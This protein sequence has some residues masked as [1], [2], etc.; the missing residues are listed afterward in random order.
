[1]NFRRSFGFDGSL[2]FSMPAIGAA[3]IAMSS[4]LAGCGDDDDD[5]DTA[6]ARVRVA[7]LS[8][9][10]PAVD[11]CLAATGSG[12]FTG[13][14][15]AGAGGAAG[16]SYGKVTKYLDVD[17]QRYDV[18]LVAPGSTSC[19]T[20]LA[21]LPDYTQ[22][23]ALA[24]D[25]SFT[26]AA[27]GKLAAGGA[28][29]LRAYV[30]DAAVTAAS[31]KLRFIHASPATPNVDVGLGGGVAFTPVFSGVAFGGIQAGQQGYVA[32]GPLNAVEISARAT[33][34]TADVLA[35]KPASLPAGAI[36]TAF[37]IGEIGNAQTPLRVLLC[38]DN[39]EPVGLETSCAIVGAA[40][41]RARIR[42]AH[43]SP[44]APA[45]D[46]CVAP[47]GT[48]TFTGP[49][50]K[51]L[52]ATAGLSYPQITEYVSLPVASFKVRV[53][54]AT[55]T[56]CAT[57][58]VP[59]TDNVALA[60]DLIATVAAVGVL[61]PSGPAAGNPAFSLAVFGDSL[62]VPA[63]SIKLRFVHASPGTPAVDV[64]LLANQVFTR[65]FANVAF[66][67]IG[68]NTGLDPQ[69]YLQTTPIAAATISA[70][71]ANAA[72]DALVVPGVTLPANAIATAFAIGGKTGATTNP[73]R[74]LLCTD[75]VRTGTLLSQ[76]AVAP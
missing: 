66:G 31:A 29:T 26:I 45:V 52:G 4:M 69:G 13:P 72:T 74:V 70:R 19:A 73:L 71:V 21:G 30:D 15:L 44:D 56:T 76:C 39:A 54:L 12:V 55:A 14:V 27:T 53:V 50:L 75:S 24:A 40:P 63:G 68:T 42:I 47:S 10:A 6:I 8:P 57:K 41:E 2:I 65:L 22:L 48:E 64:G 7:H 11:F 59:D 51:S 60:K 61:D 49:L 38:V 62:T 36:A 23:P 16:L 9:D 33:G 32:T 18:R 67:K 3:I 43:L 20:S 28:F 5:D 37:A 1:M 34:T 58:A 17:A 46:I 25:G 35:I